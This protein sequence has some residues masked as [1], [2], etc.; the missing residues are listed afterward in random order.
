MRAIFLTGLTVLCF[1]VIAQNIPY[2]SE[3][4]RNGDSR[5][6]VIF[7]CMFAG[8]QSGLDVG[9]TETA[10]DFMLATGITPQQVDTWGHDATIYIS[11]ELAQ[12]DWTVFW[13][14]SCE[15]PFQNM[16]EAFS[17]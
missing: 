4:F 2:Q 12:T 13:H 15:E 17:E 3:E 9:A 10:M 1:P 11:Q 5:I 16:R 6:P 14:T 8:Q 7:A